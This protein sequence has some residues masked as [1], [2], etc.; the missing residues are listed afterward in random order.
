MG[1][2]Y[3]SLQVNH[4]LTLG[5]EITDGQYLHAFRI[6]R[7]K[8]SG[9]VRFEATARR[10]PLKAVPIWTAFVTQYVP[11]R[12]WMK[13][14]GA[15]TIRFGELH[16]YVFCDGYKLPKG[17]KGKYQ[18]T[19]TTAEGMIV[20]YRKSDVVANLCTR[21]KDLQGFISSHQIALELDAT[22]SDYST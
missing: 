20:C 17:P 4:T 18:L 16:P 6:F 19:F 8:D 2:S 15:T 11:H 1:K 7:D 21:R 12:G 22:V 5:S 3:A 9:C 10:G 14:V 13:R